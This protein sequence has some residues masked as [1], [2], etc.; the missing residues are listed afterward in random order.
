M[1]V[2]LLIWMMKTL[3]YT[4]DKFMSL[5]LAVLN[6]FFHW[7]FSFLII[8]RKFSCCLGFKNDLLVMPGYLF[9]LWQVAYSSHSALGFK[10]PSSACPLIS[11]IP[12]YLTIVA[13]IM[14]YLIALPWPVD[15]VTELPHSYIVGVGPAVGLCCNIRSILHV[16]LH[17]F[18][19]Y[20]YIT[21]YYNLC[22]FI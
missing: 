22:L 10:Y 15:T 18:Y 8:L 1:N 17:Y 13:L 19:T 4:H 20:Y 3:S 21:T 12:N 11:A 9:G 14:L 5:W 2:W 7:P 16:L 6:D